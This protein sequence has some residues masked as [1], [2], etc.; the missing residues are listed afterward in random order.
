MQLYFSVQNIGN[1]NP[2]IVSG[3][4]GNPG[5]GIQTPAGEDVM[6]RYFTIGVRGSL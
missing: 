4:S 5:A 6:G 3:S 2:P 1:Q